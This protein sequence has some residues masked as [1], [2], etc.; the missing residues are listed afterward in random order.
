MKKII[1]IL[2]LINIV[3]C[4]ADEPRYRN[5]FR[6]SNK[7][8]EFKLIEFKKD[9]VLIGDEYYDQSKEIK[10]GLFNRITKRRIR[11]VALSLL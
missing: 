5:K 8:Y 11:Y 9:S 10:W 7:L 1:I 6:S 3:N 4:Y 2:F